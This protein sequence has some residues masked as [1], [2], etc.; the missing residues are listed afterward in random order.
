MMIRIVT[1]STCDL[2]ADLAAA[3]RIAVISMFINFGEESFLDGVEI[4]RSEFYTRI[5]KPGVHPTTSVPGP[6]AFIREY[7]R[8]AAQGATE[9]ISIHLAGTL[10]NVVQVARLAAEDTT[11]L[12]VT[13]VDGE[14]V[15]LGTGVLA[16]A[17]A[18][19][20]EQGVGREKIL[21]QLERWI[22]RTHT[23]AALD[24][25]EYL[26]RSGRL[27]RLQSSLGTW[28]NVKPII[29]MHRGIL[30]LERVRT[31]LQAQKRL[32][33]LATAVSPLERLAFLHTNATA[34]LAEFQREAAR[35]IPAGIA[36][37]VGEVTPVIGSHV[38]PGAVGMV[39]VS[40]A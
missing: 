6:Y 9:V 39:C 21:A 5:A 29:T 11:S 16:M 18:E 7:D 26:R 1:D 17:A 37:V 13:V 27:N 38:G 3:R 33:E 20:A 30:G 19:A 23:F 36:P 40:V 12:H 34:R 2:P 10:S 25:L 8:L 14:Q 31:R 35:L 15:S 22:A 32:I 28:L 4:S 24:T